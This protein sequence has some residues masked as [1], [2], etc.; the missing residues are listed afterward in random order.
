MDRGLLLGKWR[1]MDGEKPVV[2]SGENICIAD[3]L[4]SLHH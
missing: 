4:D 1:V 3:G 2:Q